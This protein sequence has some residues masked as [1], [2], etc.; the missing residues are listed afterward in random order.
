MW[1]R[2][3]MLVSVNTDRTIFFFNGE[4]NDTSKAKTLM[5]KRQ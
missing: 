2:K 4:E 5:K 1:K 3:E